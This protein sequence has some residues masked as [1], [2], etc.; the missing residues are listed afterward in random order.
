M[1][2]EANDGQ[3]YPR[4]EVV[5]PHHP[6]SLVVPQPPDAAPLH[7]SHRL[8]RGRTRRST[9]RPDSAVPQ[10]PDAAPLRRSRRL[11]QRRTRRST[12]RQ[13]S[14]VPQSPNAA[15]LRHSRR[16]AQGRTRRST[17]RQEA[18]LSF[19]NG[20]NW[21]ESHLDA[22]HVEIFPDYPMEGVVP[23]NYCPEDLLHRMRAFWAL[24]RED[25]YNR[26][27][28]TLATVIAEAADTHNRSLTTRISS[29][30]Y[31][32]MEEIMFLIS[33]YRGD[34]SY[35]SGTDDEGKG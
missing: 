25:L 8:A 18:P 9:G 6:D 2:N 22:L 13:D 16:L 11:A 28:G 7:R 23:L 19:P 12:G 32:C 20:S 29:G 21:D 1:A 30:V 33:R 31:A 10:S 35:E 17:G 27:H 24:D 4:A 5:S 34:D 3:R 15:L 26:N 14:A